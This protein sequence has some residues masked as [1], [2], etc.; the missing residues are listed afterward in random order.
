MREKL[1]E[2]DLPWPPTINTYWN[3]VPYYCAKSR[4]HRAKFVLSEKGKMYKLKC[5]AILLPLRLKLFDKALFGEF[6][7]CSPDKR[8]RDSDNYNKAVFDCMTGFVYEDDKQIKS[9]F[10][11]FVKPSKPGHVSVSL[12]TYDQ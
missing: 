12:Y 4:K 8:I 3:P 2:I 6:L 9:Y 10:V 11:D 7:Y 5:K 1:F